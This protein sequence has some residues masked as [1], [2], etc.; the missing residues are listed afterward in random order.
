MSATEIPENEISPVPKVSQRN[1]II[2]SGYKEPEEIKNYNSDL[3][4]YCG[5]KRWNPPT[6]CLL[7]HKDDPLNGAKYPEQD[8]YT[9]M[10]DKDNKIY[11]RSR[12]FW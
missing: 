8:P 3:C 11:R 2:K 5:K 6:G 7:T 9:L 10:R 12:V 4:W 1:A